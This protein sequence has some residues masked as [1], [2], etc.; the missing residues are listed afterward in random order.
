MTVLQPGF[1]FNW[2]Y[3]DYSESN[4]SVDNPEKDN[5]A[6]VLHPNPASDIVSVSLNQN[7]PIGACERCLTSMEDGFSHSIANEQP[8]SAKIELSNL[9]SGLYVVSVKKLKYPA[10]SKRY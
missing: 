3:F 4:L 1:N 8:S 5:D 7:I 10:L 6:I 9:Q 2:F